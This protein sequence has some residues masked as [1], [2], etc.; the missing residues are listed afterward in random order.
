MSEQLESGW[1]NII[2]DTSSMMKYQPH[3]TLLPFSFQSI[4]Y[5][6]FFSADGSPGG[7]NLSHEAEIPDLAQTLQPGDEEVD[8]ERGQGLWKQSCCRW[9][10]VG[11]F[12]TYICIYFF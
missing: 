11:S 12:M 4:T 5:M 1:Y 3:G 10:I 6:L 2:P 9:N 8:A 7:W